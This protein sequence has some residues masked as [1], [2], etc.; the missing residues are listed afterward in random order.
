MCYYRP[1]VAE[2]HMFLSEVDLSRLASLSLV[3]KP[4]SRLTTI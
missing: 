3:L 4:V 1:T 2:I